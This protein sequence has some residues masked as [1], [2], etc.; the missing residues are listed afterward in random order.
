MLLSS[1]LTKY[2]AVCKLLCFYKWMLNIQ[3]HQERVNSESNFILT[4]ATLIP[5]PIIEDYNMF[6]TSNKIFHLIVFVVNK[7]D[8]H[9]IFA[10]YWGTS[11]TFYYIYISFTLLKF[12]TQKTNFHFREQVLIKRNCQRDTIIYY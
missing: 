9:V 4:T 5:F 8:F 11:W 1:S 3:L 7:N 2:N 12:A 10:L 6:W